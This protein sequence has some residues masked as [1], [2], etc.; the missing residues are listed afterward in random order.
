MEI[1]IKLELTFTVS[2]EERADPKNW[3]VQFINYF[4]QTNS[5]DLE[6]IQNLMASDEVKTNIEVTSNEES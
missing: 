6:D 5:V 3:K 2:A 4:N 1:K